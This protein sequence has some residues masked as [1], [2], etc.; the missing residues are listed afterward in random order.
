[1]QKFQTI[2]RRWWQLV[3]VGG[4]ILAVIV[5]LLIAA[6]FIKQG[7]EHARVLAP[8]FVLRDQQGRLTS[9][10]QFRGKVVVLTF[11]DPECTQ[12]CPLTTQSMVEA[13]NILGPTAASQV[14][15]LGINVNPQKTRVAD[16]AAY[17]REHDLQGRWRFLTGFRRQL[18]SVWHHYHVYVSAANGDIV[19]EA[20][21]FLINPDGYESSIYTTPMS[22]AAVGDQ[23]QVLAGKIAR[24]LPGIPAGSLASQPSPQQE[25]PLTPAETAELAALG[26][27]RQSVVVGGDHPHL[28]L[29][30][31]GWLAQSSDLRKDLAVLDSYAAH[32]QRR[33]WPSPVAVD[34]LTAEPSPAE[35]RK[36]L[37]PLAATLHTPIVE[38]AS[39]RLADG[40]QVQDLPWLVL[41]SPSG[42]ILWSHDG[43]ISVARLSRD[44]RASLTAHQTGPVHKH[45]R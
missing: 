6:Y 25:D 29:F 11:I 7:K 42:K 13:L 36:A 41:A 28:L 34:E 18:E 21:V 40:Y 16:V 8:G 33:G 15:L 4:V 12:L 44:V 17:T 27:K 9:L 1:M 39:G 22:Y 32:A 43:W 10:E 30:F 24:L 19:H 20:V 26:P 5:T 38:D 23:A 37:V 35:A 2:L 14:Q 3:T 31:A 45:E